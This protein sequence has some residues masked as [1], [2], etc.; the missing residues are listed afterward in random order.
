MKAAQEFTLY[1]DN[2]GQ[3]T[4][5]KEG[6]DKKVKKLT[7]KVGADI[8]KAYEKEIVERNIEYADI[9]YIHKVPQLPKHLGAVIKPITTAKKMKIN[10]R[11]HS[12]ESLLKLY[13]DKGFSALRAIGIKFK[14]KGR[15]SMGLINDILNAQEEKQRTG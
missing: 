14:V 15:S 9:E 4:S 3:I 8:P 2:N 5:Y 1:I 13:N 6:D 12:K 11:Q 10:K 7:V